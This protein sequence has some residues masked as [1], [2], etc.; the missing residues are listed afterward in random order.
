MVQYR[1]IITMHY[2]YEVDPGNRMVTWSMTS[3]GHKRS[4]SWPHYLWGALSP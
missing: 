1:R 3:R 4:N 2:P